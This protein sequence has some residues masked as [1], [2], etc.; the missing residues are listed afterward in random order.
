MGIDY[1]KL[2]GVDKSASADDI[3]KAY[4][5]VGLGQDQ[6]SFGRFPVLFLIESFFADV[7]AFSCLLVRACFVRLCANS[8][9]VPRPIADGKST[10]LKIHHLS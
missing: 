2:L 5:K 3:K 1:Y 6:S 7:R 9:T 4:K 8:T 10:C